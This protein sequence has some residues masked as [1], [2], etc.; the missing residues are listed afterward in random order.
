MGDQGTVNLRN[1]YKVGAHSPRK[2][3][4]GERAK[5]RKCV[6]TGLTEEGKRRTPGGSV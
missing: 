5:R 1:L 2:V 6:K 4:R 3:L